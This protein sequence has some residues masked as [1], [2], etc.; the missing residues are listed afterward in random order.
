MIRKLHRWPG[1]LAAALL[2]TVAVSGALLSVFPALERAAAP[3]AVSGQSVADLATLALAA[4]PGVEQIRRA[5]S[6]KITVWW[7]DGGTPG[8]AVL[9]PATGRDAGSADANPVEKWLADFHRSLFLDDTGRIAMAAVAAAMLGLALSGA[10][11][12]ARRVGGWQRWFAR[13][14]GPLAGRLHTELARV[15]VVGLTLSAVTALWMAASTFDLLPDDEA[16]P[17]F[18]AQVSGQTGLSPAAMETLQATPVADLRDLTFPAA[19]DASDVYTLTTAQGVGYIDQGTGALLDWAPHGPWA[20]AMDWV[21][22]LHTGHGAALWGLALG[23]MVLTVPA[24]AVTGVLIWVRRR[25]SGPRLAG[26]VSAAAAE[27]VILVGSEG[28]STWGFAETLGRALQQA[29]QSVHLGTLSHFAPQRYAAARRIIVMTATWGDGAA[30]SSAV[31]AL[32]LIA[33]HKPRAGVPLAVLGFGDKSFSEFCAFAHDVDTAARAAGWDVLLPLDRID[34][35]SPQE[36]ARW[37]RALGEVLGH[38]LALDHQPAAPESN[39]L[40]LISR[41]DY[42]DDA[43][44][45][46]AILRFALPQVGLGARLTGRGFG[47]F[48]PGDL[49]AIVPEGATVPR[50][51]SLASG[52]GDGFLEIA[53]RKHP[54]GLCSGQLMA[55]QPG[56]QVRAF[57]RENPA[58]RPDRGAAP[59]ILIGAGTGIGPLA[60]FI[61][62][63]GRHRPTHLWFGSRHPQADL[64]YGEELSQ[65]MR[66]GRLNGLRT[67][68]SRSARR[69]YVQDLL[70]QDAEPL[71]D[72]IAR[73]ARIMVC[74]GR[75][76]AHG[77]NEA[78]SEVLS[79]VG[80]TPVMLKSQGRYAEDVY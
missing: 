14:R 74:G 5:P 62:T 56:Q 6:G 20:Q 7:F 27:T 79:P 30:P 11:L 21:Y 65:W 71:R 38:P 52:I 37:G 67:A 57:L 50:F 69:Q 35:Q 44:A 8:A 60:G 40:T 42:T 1:L 34:R 19:G 51:Y 55:L 75:D 43:E 18:P 26:T 22:L 33:S 4:H 49:L 73:G 76:M 39:A 13:Q 28:G 66:E 59:L 53:V 64:L 12:V 36:F 17:R 47:R 25:R 23:L 58:F 3:A 32:D 24:L 48:R 2:I 70:R 10:V 46:A 31:G 16:N 80:L 78:L 41:R 54:G 61:R 9:D 63:H 72:L 29:G 77:V 15:A 68:F 45:P